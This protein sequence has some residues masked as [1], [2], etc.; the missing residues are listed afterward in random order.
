MNLSKMAK[1][2]LRLF[3]QTNNFGFRIAA[4]TA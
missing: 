4:A 3:Y 2:F 1:A